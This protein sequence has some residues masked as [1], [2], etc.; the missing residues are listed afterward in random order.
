MDIALQDPSSEIKLR[1]KNNQTEST[2]FADQT[3][4]LTAS[5]KVNGKD[6]SVD[7]WRWNW[8]CV[9]ESDN[10][11]QYQVIDGQGN[12]IVFKPVGNETVKKGGTFIITVSCKLYDNDT[13]TRQASY[14]VTVKPS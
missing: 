1:D 13:V 8:K 11:Q 10:S 2:I 4:D 6:Y 7:N 3:I 5:I 9:S 12:N 14:R